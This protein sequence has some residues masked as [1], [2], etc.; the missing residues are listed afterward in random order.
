MATDEQLPILDQPH[1]VLFIDYA[2]T[3]AAGTLC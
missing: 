1:I 3:H 2:C